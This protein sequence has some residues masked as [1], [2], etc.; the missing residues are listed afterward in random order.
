MGYAHSRRRNPPLISRAPS[1]LIRS[2]AWHPGS[3]SRVDFGNQGRARLGGPIRDFLPGGLS[4]MLKPSTCLVCTSTDVSPVLETLSLPADTNRIWPSRQDALTAVKGPVDISSCHQCGHLFNRSYDDDLV[5]YESDYENSQMFSPRFRGYAAE[6][7]DRLIAAYDLHGRHIV[8]I[9]GGRGDF[10]R[11]LCDRGNNFGVSFGPSYRP[12]PGD[13]I[14][15]NLRFVTD[16]YTEKYAGEPADLIVCRHVLEHF[17]Q[18]RE[19]IATVRRAVADRHNLV[20][21]F[22]VPNGGYIL[23][24]RAFWEFHYQHCSYFTGNSLTRL[25]TD[26]GFAVRNLSESFGGQ[27][28]AIE[29][30]GANR[31][32]S[33]DRKKQTGEERAGLEM[34]A[35]F[36]TAFAATATRWRDILDILRAGGKRVIAWGAGA[37]T[38][39]F[40]NVVDP[41]GS[42]ITH[43]VDIN[44]RKLGRFVPGSAQQ[45][46]APAALPE[47]RPDLIVLMNGMYRDEISS[48][49]DALGLNP[50]ISIA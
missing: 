9:G 36:S 23:R 4:T 15:A 16:Y 14:P 33:P 21:Y 7:S 2:Q 41:S 22:E 10:L 26:H 46:V 48:T 28:L 50:E 35:G 38:V 1:R 32:V 39:T 8:E 6:L 25:F 24:D 20:V 31:V 30:S 49:L 43:V 18:P 12:A 5:D 27:F 45:I 42:R 17:W 44:P 11:I 19:F 29:V 34:C 3:F 40:L 13:E 47:L 37:K